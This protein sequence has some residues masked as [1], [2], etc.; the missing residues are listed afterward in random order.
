MQIE[1]L[2][3]IRIAFGIHYFYTEMLLN[4]ILRVDKRAVTQDK[5][6]PS[7]YTEN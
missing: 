1:G 7:T 5:L 3:S 6:N 4:N 2:K